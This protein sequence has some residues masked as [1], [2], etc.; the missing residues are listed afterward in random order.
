MH[1]P[2]S[3]Q[4]Y[5]GETYITNEVGGIDIATV[6]PTETCQICKGIM[7]AEFVDN[8]FGP[9]AVQVSPFFCENC[10]HEKESQ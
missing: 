8:G 1:L 2:G 3:T 10:F 9:Y 6:E 4:L 5:Q 7:H